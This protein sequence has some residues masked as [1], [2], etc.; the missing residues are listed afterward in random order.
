[1]NTYEQRQEKRRQRYQQRAVKAHEQS[2]IAYE[3]SGEGLPT[4]GQPILVGHHS[5]KRHRRAIERSHRLMDKCVA[6]S[7]KAKHYEQKAES[8]GTGGISSDDPDAIAK[9]KA[10]LENLERSQELMKTVNAE[11]RKFKGDW[12]KITSI[13][14]DT[15]QILKKD[16]AANWRANPRP[17]EAFALQNNNAEIHRVRDRIKQLEANANLTTFEKEYPGFT[18][19]QDAEENR[20]MFLFTD[21]PDAETRT[22]L[23]RY[24][25]KW[26]P[27]NSAWQRQITGNAAYAVQ[28]LIDKLKDQPA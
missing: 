11:F 19:R 10:K 3:R 2:Q 20:Y 27:R 7:K 21:K 14:E 25:F 8:V 22:L 24:A 28:C 15:K 23:K 18:F 5:E 13:P 6:E 17:F 16:M 9:L 1:M 4:D 12:T 26:S